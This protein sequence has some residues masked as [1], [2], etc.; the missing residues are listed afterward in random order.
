MSVSYIHTLI[1]SVVEMVEW[2][3]TTWIAGSLRTSS[4]M[5]L[6][7]NPAQISHCWNKGHTA[8]LSLV[9]RN[10]IFYSEFILEGFY[11][12]FHCMLLTLT[13]HRHLSNSPPWIPTQSGYQGQRYSGCTS[14]ETLDKR[15]ERRGGWGG[16]RE[17]VLVSLSTLS[18][19]FL[20]L[21]LLVSHLSLAKRTVSNMDSYRRK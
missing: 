15:G 18:C 11:Q 10:L 17:R 2:W 12:R 5:Q 9:K 13:Y 16:V 3:S 4:F 8:I 14:W 21:H 20:P 1:V 7:L 19:L 6:I